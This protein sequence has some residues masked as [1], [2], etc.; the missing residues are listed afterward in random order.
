[1]RWLVV[2][3]SLLFAGCSIV[4]GWK[5]PWARDCADR[6]TELGAHVTCKFDGRFRVRD[7]KR[8]PCAQGGGLLGDGRAMHIA[9]EYKLEIER[10]GSDELFAR[11][12]VEQS[13]RD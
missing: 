4:G 8:H 9:D 5:M 3:L 6:P 11:V 12:K 7:P 2:A 10:A 13:V 1:M